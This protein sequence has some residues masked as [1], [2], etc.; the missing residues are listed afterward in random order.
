MGPVIPLTRMV[1]VEVEVEDE[2]PRSD[3]ME[4]FGNH[5]E[6]GSGLAELKSGESS[7]SGEGD[8][9]TKST[10]TKSEAKQKIVEMVEILDEE[11][12]DVV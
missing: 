2:V 8:T 4:G 9:I 7:E 10:K 3:G 12:I 1:A 6:E 5:D 11:A